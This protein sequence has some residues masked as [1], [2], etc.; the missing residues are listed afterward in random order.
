[1]KKIAAV[2]VLVI[3]CIFIRAAAAEISIYPDYPECI[4]QNTDY[5]VSVSDGESVNKLK[6]YSACRQTGAQPLDNYRRF[7]EFGFEGEVTVRIASD[8]FDM[9]KFQIMPRSAANNAACENGV[10]TVHLS[11]P[12]SFVINIGKDYK[13]SLCVFAESLENDAPSAGDQNTIYYG[14]G[15]HSEDDIL[16]VGSGKTLYLAPGC[17]LDANVKV[18]GSGAVICG[19]GIL[20]DKI[21]NASQKTP[22]L[23]IR[24]NAKNISIRDIKL[25]DNNWYAVVGNAKNDNTVINNI[26]IM[27]NK[28]NSDAVS[29]WNGAKNIEVKN[30][31]IFNGDNVFVFK[32]DCSGLRIHDCIVGTYGAL[33]AFSHALTG[34]AVIYNIDVFAADLVNTANMALVV[35]NAYSSQYDSTKSYEV[36]TLTHRN[37]DASFCKKLP[38]FFAGNGIG[39]EKK[40]FIF[41]N[42]YLPDGTDGVR[43]LSGGGYEF[44]LDNVWRGSTLVKNDESA[45]ITDLGNETSTYSYGEGTE[46]TELFINGYRI[47]TQNAPI[48]ENGNMLVPIRAVSAAFG[49]DVAWNAADSTVLVSNCSETVK[50]TVG[51]LTAYVNGVETPLEFPPK[52]INDRTYVPIRFLSNAFGADISYNE[53][54]KSIF[55]ESER[56]CVFNDETQG[57]VK[58]GEEMLVNRCFE[59]PIEYDGGFYAWEAHNDAKIY[60]VTNGEEAFAGKSYLVVSERK[61]CY[62]GVRQIITKQLSE[63]GPGKYRLASYVKAAP[64]SENLEGNRFHMSLSLKASGNASWQNYSKYFTITKDWQK[65]ENVID[66]SWNGELEAARFVIVGENGSLE[67]FWVDY[68]TA[69]AAE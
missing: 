49:L 3:G 14:A 60:E 34:D 15:Y 25:L 47:K 68:C 16:T 61:N 27:S 65:V 8:K 13:T 67:D 21:F 58:I 57:E 45:G 36:N 12:Q 29:F 62:S 52:I 31:I 59:R 54:S 51:S 18:T 11:E 23:Y 46:E 69:K 50:L 7:A 55:I 38:R 19:R 9:T 43:I 39:E 48:I 35:N 56:F 64:Q 53:N 6:V 40:K 10:V 63:N 5:K 1:M 66:V 20:R 2:F 24:D 22:V 37:I 42:V 17:V 32:G 41:E 4:S 44:E 28:A 30:S 33:T 26:K